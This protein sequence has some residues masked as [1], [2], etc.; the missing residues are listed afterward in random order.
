MNPYSIPSLFA[1]TLYLSLGVY[2]LK[3]NQKG[4]PNRAFILI[5]ACCVVWGF[6]EFME[7]FS[8]EESYAI[9]ALFW[10][11]FLNHGLVFIPPALVLFVRV[12]PKKKYLLSLDVFLFF[13]SS[14]IF[15]LFIRGGYIIREVELYP[16][17]FSVK[18]DRN[19]LIYETYVLLGGLYAT[20]LLLNSYLSS[21]GIERK[22]AKEVLIALLVAILF[23][24]FTVY[25][26]GLLGIHVFPLASTALILS[27]LIIAHT[28]TKHR[29]FLKP[30]EERG[31]KTK[32]LYNLEKGNSYL[33]KEPKVEKSL[34]IFSNLVHNGIQ[35]ILITRIPPKRV[36]KTY[37]LKKTPIL[38]LSTIEQRE[39]VDPQ[40]LEKIVYLVSDFLKNAKDSLVMLQGIE[41]LTIENDFHYVIRAIHFLNDSVILQNS[42]FLL[43]IDPKTLSERELNF[44]EREF[45]TV[46]LED[47]Q[48]KLHG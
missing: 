29:L 30:V 22:Q 8:T 33:I 28:T 14:F 35:G 25:L 41:Y 44:L 43:T 20:Y 23:G 26:P 13:L 37:D 24:L 47:I 17:G 2:V 16:Q 48:R 21:A 12:F 4:L 15:L 27:A 11:K 34:E 46:E 5:M 32:L 40:N 19:L 39:S 6:G 9:E 10:A 7:K 42:R 3:A 18:E 45:I 31:E 38:W 1:A 36:R